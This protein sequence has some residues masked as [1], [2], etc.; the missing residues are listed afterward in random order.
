MPY[1]EVKEISCKNCGQKM[2]IPLMIVDERYV[3]PKCGHVVLVKI[4]IVDEGFNMPD[5]RHLC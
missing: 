2:L 5:P 1:P 3:C 4:K